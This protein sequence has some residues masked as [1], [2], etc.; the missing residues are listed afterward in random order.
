MS[1]DILRRDFLYRAGAV[2]AA[3]AALATSSAFA[4]ESPTTKAQPASPA[5][6]SSPRADSKGSPAATSG[7]VEQ[8]VVL[9]QIVRAAKERIPEKGW[10]YLM[11]AAD[12]ETTMKRNR[13]GLDS[14]AFK[15]RALTGVG[16]VDLSSELLGHK[17]RIP[18]VL[19]GVGSVALMH[20][21]G[22]VPV[23]RAAHKFGVTMGVSSEA[24][25]GLEP[26]GMAAPG[27]K[28]YQLYVKGDDAWIDAICA[29]AL[30]SGYTAFGFTVDSA[31]FSRRERDI[32]SAG[33]NS[34]LS[35]RPHPY[36]AGLNWEILAR[37]KNRHPEL[38]MVIKGITCGED[39]AL[40]CE[41]GVSA[42]WVSTHGG[43]QLDHGR[44]AID[45]LPEVVDSVRGRAQ[46]IIDS[47][48]SRGADVVKAIAYGAT[49]VGI[50]RLY[51]YG[52]GAGGEAGVVR[53]LEILEKEIHACMANLGARN[54]AALNPALVVAARPVNF[55]SMFSAFPLMDT[56]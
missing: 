49:A 28:I 36:E 18:F 44:G 56:V 42:V 51:C 35:D 39:A 34:D 2:T 38:P 22:G 30:A 21:D 48:F 54:I 32:V 5:E 8:F 25:P 17:M 24:K 31:S 11:G 41:I 3:G 23:A 52:L 50:G 27:P 37:F 12:T 47:G 46:I 16:Q 40:A 26:I 1:D 43:R 10:N 45:I 29:R 55:P 33:Q 4:D 7:D 9:H 13:M 15:P 19:S 20:P 6:P 53:V 14:I